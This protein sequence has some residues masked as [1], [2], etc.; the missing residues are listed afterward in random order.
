MPFTTM[1][2][3]GILLQEAPALRLPPGCRAGWETPAAAC[4]YLHAWKSWK[5]EIGRR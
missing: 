4:S 3:R 5:L 2:G 1:Q